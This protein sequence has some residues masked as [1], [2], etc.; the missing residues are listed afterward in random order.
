M[1]K[2]SAHLSVSGLLLMLHL[3]AAWAHE[4]HGQ[5]GSNHWHATDVWGFLVAAAAGGLVWWL[6][7]RK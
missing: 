6:I 1:K 5:P 4:G 7:R 3:P 2:L